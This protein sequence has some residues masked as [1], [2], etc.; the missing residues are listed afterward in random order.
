MSLYELSQYAAFARSVDESKVEIATLPG[1]P[2]QRGAVSYWILNPKKTQE[3]I[4]RMI[5][6]EKPS[7]NTADFKAGIMYTASRE[8]DAEKIK[9]QL[10]ELGYNVNAL[11]MSHLAHSQFIA[12]KNAVSIDFYHWL[13]K[14]IPDLDKMQ[15]IYDPTENYSVGSDFTIVLTEGK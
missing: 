10:I 9:Q 4:N 14:K 6:R 1:A 12:N 5:Y 7:V 2:N 13:Q 8:D 15:F 3:V 11:K